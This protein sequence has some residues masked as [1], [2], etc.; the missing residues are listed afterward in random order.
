MKSF[1]MILPSLPFNFSEIVVEALEGALALCKALRQGKKIPGLKFAGIWVNV[2][3]AHR[4]FIYG[5]FQQYI[6]NI[7]TM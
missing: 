4:V 7:Y 1:F 6:Y 2:G 5:Y 3:F